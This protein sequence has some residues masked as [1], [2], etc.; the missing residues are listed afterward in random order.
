MQIHQE[1]VKILDDALGL[2]TSAAALSDGKLLGAVPEL[3]S[4]AV[5]T[6]IGM[7]EERFGIAFDDD[8]LDASSFATVDSL[9]ALVKSKIE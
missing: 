5:V 1:V 6:V 2:S 4:M 9:V 7:L 3:D 8:E